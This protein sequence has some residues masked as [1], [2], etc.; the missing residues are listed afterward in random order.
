M[1]DGHSASDG[2]CLHRTR[3]R[4]AV[5]TAR[6]LGLTWVTWG[7]SERESP[8]RTL[9]ERERRVIVVRGVQCARGGPRRGISFSFPF[10]TYRIIAR[11]VDSDAPCHGPNAPHATSDIAHIRAVPNSISRTLPIRKVK[12]PTL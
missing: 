7:P 6:A 9:N 8:A 10:K 12:R 4:R 1:S 2:R 3:T 5:L 11:R